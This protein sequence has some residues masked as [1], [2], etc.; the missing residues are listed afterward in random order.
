[1]GQREG[2]A[3]RLPAEVLDVEFTG[4]QSQVRLGTAAG[5]LVVCAADRPQL[6]AGDAVTVGLAAGRL[7]FFDVDSELR[8]AERLNR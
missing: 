4:A 3:A 5:P 6:A 7:H 1:V 8:L 2:D